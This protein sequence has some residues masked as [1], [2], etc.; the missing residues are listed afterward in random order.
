AIG[1][2]VTVREQFGYSDEDAFAVGLTCGGVIDIMVT[3][4]RADSPER[5]VLRAALSAAVS[6]AGAALARVVSGP[7]RFLGRALLVRADGTHEGGL[8]GTPEL[9]RTAA[10]EA[11]A[12]LDAGRTGTVPLSEDGTH[13]PGGLTLLVESSV[14]PPRMIVFGAV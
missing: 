8:G 9:D 3:P 5:A 11:S 10:A 14:P 4:V 12:L 13:C 1:D 2:G 7:D 6:G